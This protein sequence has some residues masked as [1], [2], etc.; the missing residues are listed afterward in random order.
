MKIPLEGQ[1]GDVSGRFSR[2]VFNPYTFP[3]DGNSK[4]LLLLIFCDFCDTLKNGQKYVIF[5][6]ASFKW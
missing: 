5:F 2:N 6:S 3:S 1:A 4:P